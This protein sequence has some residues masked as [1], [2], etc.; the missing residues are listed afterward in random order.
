MRN[1]IETIEDAFAFQLQR[2][3]Y[4]ENSL[5]DEFATCC[6]HVT[7]KPLRKEIKDYVDAAYSKTLKLERIFNYVMK[8]PVAQKNDTIRKLLHETR[9]V[10]SMTG[11][12]FLKDI[13]LINA[14]KDINA[15]KT[16]SYKNLYVYSVELELDTP[17]DLLQQILQW[18]VETGRALSALVFQE[19]NKTPQSIQKCS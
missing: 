12:T 14:I 4:M 9:E 10:L 11:S 7:S 18:E 17:S 2:L 6:D 13:L 5:R 1:K 16:S 19:F 15:Y 3:Y 8:E